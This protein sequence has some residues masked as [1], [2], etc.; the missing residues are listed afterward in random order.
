MSDA[1]HD[2]PAGPAST[3]NRRLIAAAAGLLTLASIG[4]AVQFY[5]NV[6]GVLL[7]NEQYLAGMLGLGMALVY[8]T[9]PAHRGW[10]RPSVPW[11]DWLLAAASLVAGACLFWKF[12]VYSADMTSRPL[13]GLLIAFIAI[14]LVVEAL[15]RSV[16]P[17]LAIVVIVFLGYALVGHL[18][19][20]ALAGRHVKITQLAFYLVWDPGS[21]LG[22]PLMVATTIVIAFIFF[23]QLLF[24]SGGSAFFTDIALALDGPLPRRLGQDRGDRVLPVRHD[25]GQRG[26][27][28]RLR[29]RRHHPADEARR[30]SRPRRRGDRSGGLDRRP[31]DA[32]G[33]G[34]RRLPHGG[35]PA[36]ALSRRGDRRDAAGA[37]LLLCAVHPGRSDGRA[38]RLHPCRRHADPADRQGAQAGL[39]FP[40]SVRRADLR[41]VLAQLVAG[42]VGA[43]RRRGA[44]GRPA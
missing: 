20:G 23:G 5:R 6:L 33:D 11:Y 12:P 8:L 4:F 26:E 44:G 18:V 38:Q 32:A 27:Q 35:I 19:P 36:G 9:Q 28:R 22:L 16:G 25:L 1:T 21:M 2:T 37:A 17:P 24:A 39:A 15:R 3:A 29:R 41:A 14:P 43:R 42:T 7:F 30:L 10:S 31:A 13:D 34:R 40:A